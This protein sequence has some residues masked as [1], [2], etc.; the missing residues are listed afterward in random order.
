MAIGA[1]TDVGTGVVMGGMIGF[2]DSGCDW[3]GAVA[4]EGG[5]VKVVDVGGADC[6]GETTY[7]VD[8][9]DPDPEGA[10]DPKLELDPAA[11]A[12]KLAVEGKLLPS[13]AATVVPERCRPIGVEEPDPLPLGAE[14][15]KLGR[16]LAGR[17]GDGVTG[18]S[19]KGSVFAWDAERDGRGLGSLELDM[20]SC[21]LGGPTKEPKICADPDPLR[22]S[23]DLR[24]L[25][26]VDFLLLAVSSCIAIVS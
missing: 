21:A 25:S 5:G 24:Y 11:T 23:I 8:G 14:V 9:N 7:P 6:G 17:L 1:A 12:V 18:R 15:E 13:T 2:S 26:C 10:L 3:L 20:P 16:G 4:C 22:S 19:G